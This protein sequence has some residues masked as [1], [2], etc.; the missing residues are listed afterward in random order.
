MKIIIACSQYTEYVVNI[1]NTACNFGHW[2][3]LVHLYAFEKHVIEFEYA[4][5]IWQGWLDKQWLLLVDARKE[6]RIC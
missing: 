1:W 4:R 5:R 6:T 2:N 3:I